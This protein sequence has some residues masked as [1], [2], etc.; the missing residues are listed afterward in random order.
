MA[1]TND[2]KR[3]I[4][5]QVAAYLGDLKNVKCVQDAKPE[6][7]EYYGFI[8]LRLV[9]KLRLDSD[10]TKDDP[11]PTKA[12]AK[13]EATKVAQ[14][15]AKEVVKAVKALEARTNAVLEEAIAKPKAKAEPAARKRVSQKAT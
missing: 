8:A 2:E 4:R 12:D 13:P 10:T 3:A 9:K 6:A 7:K 14:T 5:A 1:L 11:V 15:K